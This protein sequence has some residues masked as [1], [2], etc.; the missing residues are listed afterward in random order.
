[1]KKTSLT[2][3]EMKI[4]MAM[5]VNGHTSTLKLIDADEDSYYLHLIEKSSNYV[6]KSS[7]HSIL[8]VN[9]NLTKLQKK[10]FVMDKK[11]DYLGTIASEDGII[12]L[13][14]EIKKKEVS[15]IKKTYLKSTLKLKSET[16]IANFELERSESFQLYSSKS[17]D[18][19]KVGI[20]LMIADKKG[21]VNSYYAATLDKS[22]ELIWNTVEDLNLSNEVFNVDDISVTDNGAMYLVFKSRP[23]KEKKAKDKRSYLDII[24]LAEDDKNK[25]TIPFDNYID[26]TKLH[27]LKNG[28]LFI[29]GI[30]SNTVKDN[31]SKYVNM[32][33]YP[34][35]LEVIAENSKKIGFTKESYSHMI[36]YL[37]KTFDFTVGIMDISELEDGTVSVLCEQMS[38]VHI[39]IDG[40]SRYLKVRG[41]VVSFFVEND[42]TIKSDNYFDKFQKQM[43]G[44]NVGPEMLHVSIFPFAYGNK[45]GY[46]LN[47]A[48]KNYTKS[49]SKS[50]VHFNKANGKDSGIYMVMEEDGESPRAIALTG[51]SPANKYITE[52][53]SVEN[54]RLIVLTRDK[55]TAYIETISL[56]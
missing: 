1:M 47:D 9:K 23:E 31:P 29:A 27:V 21:L 7:T 11:H 45:M 24:F 6:N 4:K 56:P 22:G 52:L 33:V 30:L 50:K 19:S 40:M 41:T 10:P 38:N 48:I 42:G 55:K 20:L 35:D 15:I 28:N 14:A 16:T 44:F 54:D 12:V 3:P 36:G 8:V 39:S 25:L 34:K 43:G 17:P 18:K 46:L 13:A 49:A 26:D 53:L 37:P 32:L 5:G 2:I 51:T